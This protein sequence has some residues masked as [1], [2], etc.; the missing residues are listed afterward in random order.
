MVINWLILGIRH[1]NHLG[2]RILKN[3]KLNLVTNSDICIILRKKIK[4]KKLLKSQN[5]RISIRALLKYQKDQISQIMILMNI[6]THL[7]RQLSTL[8]FNHQVQVNDLN[9]LSYLRL[10]NRRNQI[11]WLKYHHQNQSLFVMSVTIKLKMATWYVN[12]VL[13]L[14]TSP[15]NVLNAITTK[16]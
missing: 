5:H 6:Q 12:R 9:H 7:I 13:S 2:Q 4:G 11:T 8:K 15:S 16:F 10:N 3:K 14:T 1:G